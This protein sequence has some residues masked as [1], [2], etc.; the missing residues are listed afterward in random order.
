ML[1]EMGHNPL[2]IGACILTGGCL[3]GCHVPYPSQSPLHRGLY[4]DLPSSTVCPA[5]SSHNPLFI[6]ACILTRRDDAGRENQRGHNPLFIGAC[7]LTGAP[8]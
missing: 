5:G 4:S 3:A 1:V 6:G 2:F 8:A 7:I